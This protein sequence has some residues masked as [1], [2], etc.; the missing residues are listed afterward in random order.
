MVPV[1]SWC[2][3]M[4]THFSE[5][6]FVSSQRKPV[7]SQNGNGRAWYS[8]A[9]CGRV[10]SNENHRSALETAQRRYVHRKQD[11]GIP[12]RHCHSIETVERD[13]TVHRL[14]PIQ[15]GCKRTFPKRV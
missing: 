1:R 5:R 8:A 14:Q 4:E 9:H 15:N 7:S 2:W 10:C 13:R 12:R 3:T 11:R 6:H